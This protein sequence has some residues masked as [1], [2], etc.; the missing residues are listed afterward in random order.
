M[1][2][3]VALISLLISILLPT[4]GRVTALASADVCQSRMN[5]LFIGHQLYG[6][7]NDGRF[8][9]YNNWL[10]TGPK[11]GPSSDWVK[12]GQI[13]NYV[14]DTEMYFCPKDTKARTS[15]ALAIGSGGSKGNDPIHTYVRLFEPHRQF[16]QRLAAAGVSS[17]RASNA[18]NYLRPQSIAPKAFTPLPGSA[19]PVQEYDMA[20]QGPSQLG[21]LFEEA[22]TE[23]D[24][25]G[26][27][28]AWALLNDGYSYFSFIQDMMTMRHLDQGHVIYYDGHA[29][30]MDAV[31]FNNWPVTKDPYAENIVFGVGD[32]D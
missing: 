4:L 5:Q 19:L 15:G 25:V 17:E 6:V 26:P 9:H 18:G 29:I 1:L 22:T 13:W 8:P 23:T 32:P 14:L 3:V 21:M 28:T 10:W 16:T 7:D 30:L 24:V 20:P 12:H 31:R 11:G 27:D 2:L